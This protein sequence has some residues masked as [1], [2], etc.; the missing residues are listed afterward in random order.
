MTSPSSTAAQPTAAPRRASWA[1]TAAGFAPA[2][3]A[4]VLSLLLWLALPR[5]TVIDLIH[6]GGPIE[7]LTV[8]LYVLAVAALWW[9]GGPADERLG[10]IGVGVMLL[11]F[12]AR[13]LD[14]HKALTGTSVL[15]V[16]FYLRDAPL[17]Q[18]LI[19][20]PIVLAIAAA[21]LWLL[22][23]FAKPVWQQLRLR[24]PLAV[25]VAAFIVTLV[26]TKII[27]RSFAIL[28]EDFGIVMSAS[29]D[30]VLSALE[31][32]GECALPV[33]AAVGVWQYRRGG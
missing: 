29:V 10:R 23:R 15:K 27:D 22:V 26:A 21:G 20:L 13:E 14:L 25:T 7:N 18:K 16:S 19:A 28:A 32:I 11:A 8:L 17:H 12:A 6:E 1:Y 30:T 3:F 31:E 2:L 5:D 33:I 4:V 24:R 9:V